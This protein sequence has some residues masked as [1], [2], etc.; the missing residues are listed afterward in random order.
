MADCVYCG[1]P[2]GFLRK[3]HAAC[4]EQ[5]ERATQAIPTFVEKC[6]VTQI[7]IDR[8]RDL[9]TR[10]AETSF[11]GA[12]ELNDIVAMALVR[13]MTLRL[14]ERLLTADEDTR[15]AAIMEAFDI[16]AESHGFD[17]LL[18]SDILRLLGE[19]HI[20]TR[21]RLKDHTLQLAAGETVVWVF[22]RVT[23]YRN[24]APAKRNK[25]T[26]EPPRGT[27]YLSRQSFAKKIPVATLRSDTNGDLVV[28]DR[29]LRL[30][31][32]VEPPQR[33]AI[34]RIVDIEPY[35]DGIRIWFGGPKQFAR[36]I[37][38]NDSWFATNLLLGLSALADPDGAGWLK[39]ADVPGDTTIPQ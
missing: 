31:S 30:L 8:F 6:V 22:N 12:Q 32:S 16:G 36:T 2:A 26:F 18:K 11:I 38:L 7:P 34:A 19:G 39:R 1:K 9:L 27:S 33:L 25:D 15:I 14:K 5:H 20:P 24:R 37:A 23:S 17:L 21:V 3:Q 4:R 10:A 13:L 29:S 28:T 35:D